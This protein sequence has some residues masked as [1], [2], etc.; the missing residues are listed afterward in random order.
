MEGTLLLVEDHPYVART[1]KRVLSRYA[2]VTVVRTVQ[3]A[4]DKID[5]WRYWAGILVD[6]NLHDA[7]DSDDLRDRGGYAVAKYAR[8][9][10]PAALTTVYTAYKDDEL[11]DKLQQLGVGWL[12]K[13]DRHDSLHS[14][15]QRSLAAASGLRLQEQTSRGERLLDEVLRDIITSAVRVYALTPTECRIVT[16]T[17]DMFNDMQRMPTTRQVAA[18]LDMTGGTHKS[19]VRNIV[20]KTGADDMAVLVGEMQREAAIEVARRLLQADAEAPQELAEATGVSG[21]RAYQLGDE[22]EPKGHSLGD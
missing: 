15:A 17:V 9:R 3:A 7:S 11:R 21:V 12:T 5:E 4:I 16:K 13:S 8:R 14:W 2:P 19:H 18:Q 22:E 20:G 6:L 1:A 10:R